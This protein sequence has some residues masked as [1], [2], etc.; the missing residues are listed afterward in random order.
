MGHENESPLLLDLSG[1][2]FSYGRTSCIRDC[3][4]EIRAEEL[5]GLIGPNGSGKSTLLRLAAGILRPAAGRVLV[6]GEAIVTCPG[7]KRAGLVAFLPQLLDMDAPFRVGEL[8]GMGR[9]VRR[10]GPGSGLDEALAITGLADRRDAFLCE[11]SGGERRRAYIAMTLVQG[12]RL[13]L[14]DEPLANLDL[15]YQL[16]CLRLLREISRERGV[17]LFVS[18]HDLWIATLMDRLVMLSDGELLA[19]GRPAEV[20]ALPAVRQAFDPDD[21]IDWDASVGSGFRPQ[22]E[23]GA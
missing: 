8:V 21:A 3:S 13:L 12:S 14:L 11:L 16:E 7:W 1:V 5:V 6:A 22:G 20:L 9:A 18:L 15:R 2:S 19:A 10:G 17:S 23:K 4:L